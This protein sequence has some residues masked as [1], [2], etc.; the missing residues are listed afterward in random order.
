MEGSIW[1]N[2]KIEQKEQERIVDRNTGIKNLLKV[3]NKKKY[4]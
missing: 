3:E 1:K 4:T 2:I